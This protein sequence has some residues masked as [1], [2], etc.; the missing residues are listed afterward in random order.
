M[1]FLQENI[2][3]SLT[4]GT[5]PDGFKKAVA[6]PIHKKDCKTEKPNYRPINIFPNLSK[7]KDCYVTRHIITWRNVFENTKRGFRKCYNAQLRL[8]VKTEKVKEARNKNR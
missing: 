3:Y 6:H 1:G 2:N 7:M 8:L 5:Y 4:K